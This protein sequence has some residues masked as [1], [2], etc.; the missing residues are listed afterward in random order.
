MKKANDLLIIRGNALYSYNNEL[1][2]DFALYPIHG[3]DYKDFVHSLNSYLGKFYSYS[4]NNASKKSS[5]AIL[6]KLKYL[7]TNDMVLFCAGKH[8]KDFSFTVSTVHNEALLEVVLDIISKCIN[9]VTLAINTA[10]IANNKTFIPLNE[11]H[12]V[13]TVNIRFSQHST[14]ERYN[15]S[16]RSQGY[17]TVRLLAK[18]YEMV[19][20]KEHYKYDKYCLVFHLDNALKANI[21]IAYEADQFDSGM[22]RITL[23]TCIETTDLFPFSKIRAGQRIFLGDIKAFETKV[24][25]IDIPKG[26]YAYDPS[27]KPPPVEKVANHVKLRERRGLTIRRKAS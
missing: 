16:K 1:L 26:A 27:S 3:F 5:V 9:S 22:D 17:T 20:K 11:V 12:K 15:Q 19:L 23:V 7:S 18:I 10:S 24:Y 8:C 6:L 13:G 25:G 14:I 21:L 4:L 2:N